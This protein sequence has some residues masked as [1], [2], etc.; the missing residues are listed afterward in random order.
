MSSEVVVGPGRHVVRLPSPR[1]GSGVGNPDH[2][3]HVGRGEPALLVVVVP[4]QLP[5]VLL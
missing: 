4:R 5:A 3:P 1:E 2:A